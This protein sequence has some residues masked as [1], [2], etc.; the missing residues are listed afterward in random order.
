MCWSHTYR[1]VRPKL[2]TI[3][4]ENKELGESILSDIESIQWMCQTKEEFEALTRLIKEHYCSLATLTAHE[5]S[6]V[7]TFFSYFLTQWG[8]GS[9]VE[10]W[11]AGAHPFAIINNQGLEGTHKQYKKD[12]TFRSEVPLT[13][14]IQITENLVRFHL[15]FL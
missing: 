6:L 5:L 1:N 13:E 7:K 12:H 2:A 11:Y 9:H 15:F 8:P 3:R 14:F 10:N 4:K